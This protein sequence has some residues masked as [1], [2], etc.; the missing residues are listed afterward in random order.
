[1]KIIAVSTSPRKNGNGDSAVLAAAEGAKSLGAEVEIVYLRDLKMNYCTGCCLC[2]K[3]EADGCVQRDDVTELLKKFHAADGIIFCA[4]IYMTQLAGQ[5]KVLFDRC[6]SLS[7]PNRNRQRPAG[8]PPMGERKPMEGRVEAAA[9]APVVMGPEMS[10]TAIVYSPDLMGVSPDQQPRKK[11][12]IITTSNSMRAEH[13]LNRAETMAVQFKGAGVTDYK[14]VTVPGC[15]PL[16]G[17]GKT[18]ENIEILKE[19]GR[20]LAE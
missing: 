1:M 16:D 7:K 12:L 8:P 2:K 10:K 13:D 6:Y 3:D 20:W 11:M 17:G 19:V 5:A 4:P 9:S 18:E 14:L 15:H